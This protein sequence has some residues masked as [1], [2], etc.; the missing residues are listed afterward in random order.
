LAHEDDADADDADNNR[1][2]ATAP[3]DVGGDDGVDETYGC[4]LIQGRPS[5]PD[6]HLFEMIDQLHGLGR[7]VLG[8]D[9]TDDEDTT[10]FGPNNDDDGDDDPSS[11]AKVA[12]S[13]LF[14]HLR[15][16]RRSYRRQP[17]NRAYFASILYQQLPYNSASARFGSDV[18]PLR[19][20]V[21]NQPASAPWR[22][23]GVVDIP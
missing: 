8:D 1:A 2:T 11:P 6:Y 15:Q 3:G 14:P 23:L 22:N 19:S 5:A 17:A 20:Y 10:L 18:S 9:G 21:R 4:Y 7:R 12:A 13:S 16:F